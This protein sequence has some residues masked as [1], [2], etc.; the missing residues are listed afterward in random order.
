MRST[1]DSDASS[2]DDAEARGASPLDD[3]EDASGEDRARSRARTARGSERRRRR[4]RRMTRV[5]Q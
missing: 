2:D 3:G 1:A 4:H 5:A